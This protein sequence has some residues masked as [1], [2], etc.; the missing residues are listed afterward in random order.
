MNTRTHTCTLRDEEVF[1]QHNIHIPIYTNH[2]RTQTDTHTHTHRHT[3]TCTLIEEEGFMQHNIHIIQIHKLHRHTHT[4][5]H[6]RIMSQRDEDL[7]YAAADRITWCY[8][9]QYICTYIYTYI[10]IHTYNVAEERR[11]AIRSSR[12]KNLMLY[13][14]TYIHTHT[15]SH[16]RIT[17]QRDEDLPYAAADRKT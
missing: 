14:I 12:P 6:T 10:Y 9:P 1:L 15:N 3:H 2:T 16:T 4:Y 11:L 7:P 17:S 5:S 8:T 13:T